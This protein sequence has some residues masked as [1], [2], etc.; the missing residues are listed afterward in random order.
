[1]DYS[2]YTPFLSMLSSEKRFTI[3]RLLLKQGPL[4]V[5]QIVRKTGFEQSTVSHCLAQLAS[6]NYVFA[7]PNGR[8]RIYSLNKETIAPLL[9]IIDKHV[10]R[11]C[12]NCKPIGA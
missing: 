11:Y 7:K 10:R 4:K 9:R 8:E 6:C 5:S 1:M 3:I 2:E 12:P